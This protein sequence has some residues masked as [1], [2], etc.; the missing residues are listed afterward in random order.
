[1]YQPLH[2]VGR[3]ESG[4]QGSKKDNQ[5]HSDE[6]IFRKE[7]LLLN[8]DRLSTLSRKVRSCVP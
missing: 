7:S 3:T 5:E 4:C 6:D 8:S 1:M 2:K